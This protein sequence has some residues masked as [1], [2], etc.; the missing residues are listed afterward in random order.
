MA[1]TPVTPSNGVHGLGGTHDT[2]LRV[3]SGHRVAN[4]DKNL[5]AARRAHPNI[6]W[7]AC[8]VVRDASGNFTTQEYTIFF[9][10]PPAGSQVYYFDGTT[11]QPL[12][13]TDAPNKGS[14]ARSQAKLAIGDPPIGMT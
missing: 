7:F 9:N 6:N 2:E 11:A 10:R 12:S 1:E 8:Y 14:Q 13:Y 4:T 5:A 3:P